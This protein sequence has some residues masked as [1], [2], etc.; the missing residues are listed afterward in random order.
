[1]RFNI[2]IDRYLYVRI[3]RSDGCPGWVQLRPYYTFTWARIKLAAGREVGYY[4]SVDL[5]RA[6]LADKR[7]RGDR[8]GAR[9][10]IG[11]APTS[12]VRDWIL[13]RSRSVSHE[14]VGHRRHDER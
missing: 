2:N 1:M 12:L 6:H 11:R 5:R 8:D 7:A 13:A 14:T 10:V 9:A 3:R 4:L